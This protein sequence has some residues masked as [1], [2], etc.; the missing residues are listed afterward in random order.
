MPKALSD[1]TNALPDGFPQ[2]ISE[3]ISASYEARLR[4]LNQSQATD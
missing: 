4:L 3:A 1:V 2:A